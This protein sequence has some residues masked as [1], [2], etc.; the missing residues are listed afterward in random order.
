MHS[1]KDS[2][3]MKI[4]NL[5]MALPLFAL[6]A[7]AAIAVQA[8][9]NAQLGVLLG[10]A[11]MGTWVAFTA[12]SFFTLVALFVTS[13]TPPS[14]AVIKTVPLYLWFAGGIL[15]A[16]GVGMFYFLI[17]KMGI[18]LMMSFALTGQLL[19][20]IAASHFGWFNLPHM[21]VDKIKGL[22]V[23]ALIAGVILINW[24]PTA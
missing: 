21:P 18:G 15:S 23:C 16:F 12:A 11:L 6:L 17:P 20:A 19:I 13:S 9:M 24:N 4:F 1:T 2:L 5:V 7:G 10:N 22:G 14:L 8:T 3:A